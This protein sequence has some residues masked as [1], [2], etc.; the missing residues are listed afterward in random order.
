MTAI[1]SQAFAKRFYGIP[2]ELQAHILSLVDS[3]EHIAALS[4]ASR[5]MRELTVELLFQDITFTAVTPNAVISTYLELIAPKYGRHCHHLELT[6]GMSRIDTGLEDANRA[7]LFEEILKKCSARLDDANRATLFTEIL[8]TCSDQV[9]SLVLDTAGS[10]LAN[11]KSALNALGSVSFLE[12]ESLT[13]KCYDLEDHETQVLSDLFASLTR[14]PSNMPQLKAFA[15]EGH[16]HL[17]SERSTEED[18]PDTSSV[19]ASLKVF[20]EATKSLRKLSLSQLGIHPG[21]LKA[22]LADMEDLKELF[23]EELENCSLQDCF[24]ALMEIQVQTTLQ[25]L[26]LQLSCPMIP[27]ASMKIS[28]KKIADQG[29]IIFPA[30]KRLRLSLSYWDQTGSVSDL[31][32]YNLYASLLR[33]RQLCFPMLEVLDADSAFSVT[34]GSARVLATYIIMAKRSTMPDLREVICAHQT[35]ADSFAVTSRTLARHGLLLTRAEQPCAPPAEDENQCSDAESGY[36]SDKESSDKHN[37][38]RSQSMI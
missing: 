11:T 17:A 27:S 30:L 23:L 25:V 35:N 6:F 37:C 12:L 10:D 14:G 18:L 32:T 2:T 20:L 19:F 28:S 16:W 1:I 5:H 29:I 13:I 31:Y 24:A 7:T 3:Y 26:N 4:L 22:I 38:S 15:L 36:G 33:S 9:K 8:K 34:A 21:D